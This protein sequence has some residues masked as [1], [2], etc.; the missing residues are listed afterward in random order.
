MSLYRSGAAV[1]CQLVWD[2][3][4]RVLLDNMKCTGV[5]ESVS[6]LDEGAYAF[7]LET[8]VDKPRDERSVLKLV[9]SRPNAA[10]LTHSALR[11]LRALTRLSH[12]NIIPLLRFVSVPGVACFQFARYHCSLFHYKHYARPLPLH[13]IQRVFAQ[14]SSAV[15]FAHQHGVMHRDIKPGNVLLGNDNFAVLADWG[16]C[17]FMS[18]TTHEFMTGEVI[19]TWYAPPEVLRGDTYDYPADIWSLGMS[20]L[21][22]VNGEPLFKTMDRERFLVEMLAAAGKDGFSSP[23]CSLIQQLSL[24]AEGLDEAFF[25]LLFGMLHL[26]PLCRLTA[27]Q[28]ARH[29]FFLADYGHGRRDSAVV[30]VLAC[31]KHSKWRYRHVTPLFP[32]SS[33]L[34]DFRFDELTHRPVT[35]FVPATFRPGWHASANLALCRKLLQTAIDCNELLASFMLAMHVSR[36]FDGF[37]ILP[38]AWLFACLTLSIATCGP[39]YALYDIREYVSPR[40]A[41]AVLLRFD[42]ANTSDLHETEM[43]VLQK[44]NCALPAMPHEF[45][46]FKWLPANGPARK[47]VMLLLSHPAFL[48]THRIDLQDVRNLALMAQYGGTSKVLEYVKT[49]AKECRVSISFKQ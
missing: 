25:S 35:C 5:F 2:Q 40:A 39:A 7:V 11:E 46:W 15:A 23:D 22:L 27:T 29:P 19:T 32:L 14:M 13:V 26:D 1:D 12:P 47:V 17:R 10:C 42:I 33:A 31:R 34:L 30:S 38:Q 41:V 49:L 3:R 28:V 4:V 18:E 48:D 37:T 6:L 8:N 20:L 16:M 44:L 21:E 24:R 43:M 9:C 45:L 36:V